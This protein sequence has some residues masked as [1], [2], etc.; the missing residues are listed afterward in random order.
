MPMPKAFAS[1]RAAQRKK[2]RESTARAKA[3]YAYDREEERRWFQRVL[4][5]L[6]PYHNAKLDKKDKTQ[7]KARPAKRQIDL[8]LNG[9]PWYSFRIQREYSSCHCEGP[10]GCETR[11]WVAVK[12][13]QFDRKGKAYGSYFDCND[14]DN[15]TNLAQ[16]MS[17]ALRKFHDQEQWDR[18]TKNEK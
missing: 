11:D 17:S 8:W 15:E 10:C 18:I 7:V 5:A 6:K 9:K 3:A 12:A 16:A 4:A 13:F 14:W 1:L 2:A